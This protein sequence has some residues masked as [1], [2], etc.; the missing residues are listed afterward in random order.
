MTKLPAATIACSFKFKCPRSWAL[1][2]ETAIPTVRHCSACERDVHLVESDAD[3]QAHAA[4]G[5][6]VAVPVAESAA[7]GD[8]PA[9]LIG[10]PDAAYQSR[11]NRP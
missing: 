7:V 2:Q 6:C 9:Y 5:H 3:L 10:E 4:A 8:E 11:T 1:L